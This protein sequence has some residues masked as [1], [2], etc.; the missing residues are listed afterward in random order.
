MKTLLPRSSVR[1]AVRSS[2]FGVMA[3]LVASGSAAAED[4]KFGDVTINIDTTVTAGISTRVSNR[5][6]S[7][8]AKGDGGCPYGVTAG[9]LNNDNGNLNFNRW[10]LT[11]ATLSSVSDIDIKWNDSG[12]FLRPT[13]YYDAIYSQND[14]RWRNLTHDGRQAVDNGVNILDA[15]AYT[16]F[17]IGDHAGNIRVGKQVINWGESTFQRG[18]INAYQSIDVSAARRPGAELKDIIT[19]MPILFASLSLTDSLSAEAFW[20][21]GHSE[22]QIDPSGSFFSTTDIAGP[23]SIVQNSG[24]TNDATAI[25]KIYR[26]AD[27]RGSNVNQFGVALRNYFDNLG[28]GTDTG[29]YF[30]RYTSKLP[31]IGARAGSSSFTDTCVAIYGHVCSNATEVTTAYVV[32]ANKITYFYDFP[33]QI[34]EIGASFNTT[35][36]GTALSGELSFTPDMPLAT[37]YYEQ[38]ASIGDGTG[39]TPFLTSGAYTRWSR[40]GATSPGQATITHVD[41][42]TWQG[43]FTTITVFNGSDPLPSAIHADSA[44]FV[45]NPGFVYAKDAGKYPLSFSGANPGITNPYAAIYITPDYYGAGNTQA[46]YATD[47]SWGVAALLSA[48]YN[49]PWDLPITLSPVLQFSDGIQGRSPGPNTAGYAKGVKTATVGLNGTYQSWK[50]SISYTNYFGGGWSNSYTDRDFAAASVSYSF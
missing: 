26:S 29:L 30:V 11:S 20:E 6:C 24:G 1:R 37:D 12:I 19:P 38:L 35:V 21:F 4:F 22:T 25:V 50:A 42:N 15:F 16:N 32:G 28:T 47:W 31:Y 46:I 45:F 14:L 23:G 18:G 34:N 44:A 5:D 33:D 48:T 10:D 43:Q 36:G 39:A 13:A 7:H 3:L 8:I 40:L 41:L 27:R 17:E 49:N 2:L 9:G